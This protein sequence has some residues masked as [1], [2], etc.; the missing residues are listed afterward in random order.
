MPALALCR[1]VRLSGTL[2]IRSFDSGLNIVDAIEAIMFAHKSTVLRACFL[3][4]MCL[5]LVACQAISKVKAPTTM[6]AGETYTI[7]WSGGD[8]DSV[9]TTSFT[10]L[11]LRSRVET[12]RQLQTTA[13]Y[14]NPAGAV[15]P[16]RIGSATGNEF[17]WTVPD[18][19][20]AQEYRIGVSQALIP[21]MSL[22]YSGDIKISAQAVTS[23]S[24]QST[25]CKKAHMAFQ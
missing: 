16:S 3:S 12:N 6:R 1:I 22:V 18:D 5:R 10:L 20:D 11:E 17:K 23:T 25:L 19:I 24:S 13:V 9:R 4:L 7:T 2:Y 21:G 15:L 14:L 8:E